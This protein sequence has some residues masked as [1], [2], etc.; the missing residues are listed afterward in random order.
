MKVSNHL[1][2]HIKARRL[3]LG[4][5]RGEVARLL[6][7]S[8]VNK[9]CRRLCDIEDGR[10][11]DKAFLVQLTKLLRIEPQIIQEKIDCDRAEFVA[12]WN[13]WADEPVPIQIAVRWIP[14]FI[15]GVRV[16][17]DVKTPEQAVAFGQSLAAQKHKKVFVILSRR[18]T[19]GIK[20]SGEI[21]GQFDATPA[22]NPSP[23]MELSGKKF[24]IHFNSNS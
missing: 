4:L 11:L 20:E 15:A 22:D 1:G 5:G 2:E 10:R 7:Y 14:G 8:N 18:V 24:L 21:D 6:G 23:F 13:K 3:E 9:A 19:V 12:A 17:D 16:P